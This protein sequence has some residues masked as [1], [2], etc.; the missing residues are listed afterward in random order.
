[1]IRLWREAQTNT[2]TDSSNSNSDNNRGDVM[3]EKEL[4]RG[5]FKLAEER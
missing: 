2:H 3:S 1:V 4:K 5:G